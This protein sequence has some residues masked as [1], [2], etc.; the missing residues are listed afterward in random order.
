MS[1][2]SIHEN[3]FA[4]E[5][6]VLSSSECSSLIEHLGDVERAGR[7]GLLTDP[8]VRQLAHSSSILNLVRPHL[9]QP[10]VPARGIYFD[11][12]PDANWLVA[13]HQDLT[14]SVRERVEVPGFGPWSVKDGVP[15]VHPPVE[16]LEQM[17]TVRIHL[18]D[19]NTGNG[20]LRV[21]PG[22][23]ALGPLDHETIMALGAEGKEVICEA[24]AG[25][26]LL[27]RPLL[28]HAS[29]KSVVSSH[30][31]VVHLEYAGFRLPEP[32]HWAEGQ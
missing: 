22:T 31:R 25:D 5:R 17:L 15:H 13:W 21:I 11:K 20:A 8:E 23:H 2:F 18:D 14:L 16:L 9:A 10:P 4:I 1:G 28:L 32:L 19:C 3:G 27:M 12:S 26:V 6:G 29:G 30:R 24:T 7:R